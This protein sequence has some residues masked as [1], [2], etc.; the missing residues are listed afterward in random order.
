MFPV[1]GVG[2]VATRQAVSGMRGT[3]KLFGSRPSLS[4]MQ[5]GDLS[6]VPRTRHDK[7]CRLHVEKGGCRK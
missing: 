4:A 6:K 2:P 5:T 7:M 3:D 1:I